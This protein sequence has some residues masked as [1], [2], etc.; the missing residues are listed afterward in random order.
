VVI[1]SVVAALAWAASVV[2]VQGAVRDA[3]G[4]ETGVAAFVSALVLVPA[5]RVAHRF[6]ATFFDRERTV[7]LGT[8][9]AFVDDVR[10][11]RRDPEEVEELL[12]TT[13]RDPGLRVGLSS[14]GRPGLVDLHGDPAELRTDI[15]LRAGRSEIGAIEL[16]RSG[17]RHRR[18]AQEAA[19]LC[20]MAFENSR[21]R[22]GVRIALAEVE[23]SRERLE[24]AAA[25]ERR[26]LERDLHD[27]T[28]QALVAIGM[29]LRSTQ[30]GLAPGSREHTDVDRA[31][32]QLAATVG[33]LRRISQGIRPARLDDGLGPALEALRESTPIPLTITVAEAGEDGE[34]GEAVAQ[35]AY[36]LVTEAVANTLKHAHASGIE[37]LVGWR[38]GRVVVK[39][40]D[41][42]IGGIDP[43]L[44]LTG[45][46]D[47]VDSLGGT[48]TVSSPAGGGT[49]IEAVL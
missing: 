36:F 19:R 21:L 28:Q 25:T 27:G 22:V 26:R 4:L 43:N 17:A 23:A 18:L 34:I 41:D 38:G 11:G 10:E 15:A 32:E 31:V 13:L 42:G 30:A 2:L 44:P 46:R 29:R 37:V 3:A 7:L 45:L 48:L 33:E 8:V 47:R 40:A 14:P 9:R 5:Y 35:A 49:V 20:W 12:R 39:V 6:S 1:T 24:V 16:G